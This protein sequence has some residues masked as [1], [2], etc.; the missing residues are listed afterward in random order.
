M[1]GTSGQAGQH[2]AVVIVITWRYHT[3]FEVASRPE[4]LVLE[5]SGTAMPGFM[6][7]GASSSFRNGIWEHLWGKSAAAAIAATRITDAPCCNLRQHSGLSF[8]TPPN[9]I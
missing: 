4:V 3:P 5:C 2:H 8:L 1:D 7:N 6:P 9:P